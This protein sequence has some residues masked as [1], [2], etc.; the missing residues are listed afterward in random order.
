MLGK[1]FYEVE[2]PYVYYELTLSL[3]KCDKIM[4]SDIIDLNSWTCKQR[5][6]RKWPFRIDYDDYCNCCVISVC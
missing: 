3:K 4:H 5:G 1:I 2:R 6:P